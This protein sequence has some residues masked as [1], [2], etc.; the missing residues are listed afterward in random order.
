MFSTPRN[1]LELLR[2]LWV[3]VRYDA[4]IV[5]F[6]CSTRFLRCAKARNLDRGQRLARA[7][8]V[9]GPSF[10]KLGQALS[11]RTDLVGEEVADGLGN[12]RDRLP[13]FSG[14]KARAIIEAEFAESVEELFAEFDENAIAAASIAQVHRARTR[15][16]Q[17]VAV[18]VLRPG[19]EK[20]F[21]RDLRLMAWMARLLTRCV[22]STRRLK[23]PEV[24]AT[25]KDSIAFE[26]DLRFEAAAGAELAASLDPQGKFYVPTVHWSLTRQHVLTLDWVEGIAIHD[27][28]ALTKAGHDLN[29]LVAILAQSFFSQVFAHGFFHADL[30]PGNLFVDARGHIAA[31]DFGIMGRISLRDRLYLAEIFHGFLEEDFMRVAK[32]HFAAGYVPS[33]KSV[34]Q[35]ALACAAIAKPILGR[36]LNEISAG[37]LLGQL[38]TIT[39]TF[40]MQTQPQLLLLQ[41]NM[42]LVEAMGRM[43][44]PGSNLWE[45]ARPPIETWVRDNLGPLGKL[46]AGGLEA[47]TA[48]H[49][50]PH[51]MRQAHSALDNLSDPDGVRL[52]PATVKA[53]QGNTNPARWEMMVLLVATALLAWLALS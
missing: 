11:T 31:V 7:L 8:E 19:I 1:L 39:S 47:A 29:A 36:P 22:P 37:K 51:L 14:S 26:L 34:E 32:A 27:I 48:I 5:F 17:E 10:I 42:V 30:H 12:L 52:H 2:I 15:D 49:E 6:P 9:L 41:K 18:K 35:F 3:L 23:L 45:M 13:P 20:A 40:D 38:F 44:A 53:L 21:A 28:E 4:L 33:T 43:L 46:K 16:G 25:L 24:V 50:L